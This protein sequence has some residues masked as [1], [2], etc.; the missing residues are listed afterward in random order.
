MAKK[1]SCS[2]VVFWLPVHHQITLPQIKSFQYSVA[3]DWSRKWCFTERRCSV[4]ETKPS[5]QDC[6]IKLSHLSRKSSLLPLSAKSQPV[7]RKPRNHWRSQKIQP[8]LKKLR[9]QLTS[10]W[11]S[12]TR[13][14]LGRLRKALHVFQEV[15]VFWGTC[16]TVSPPLRTET[17]SSSLSLS[18]K[19]LVCPS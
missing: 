7:V 12:V 2:Q 15:C 5:S 4:W 17:A 14:S 1:K 11:E 18:S 6:W 8:A 16:S 9:R 13:D 3:L 19:A 10:H